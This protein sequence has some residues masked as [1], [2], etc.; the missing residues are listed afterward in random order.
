M[1]DLENRKVADVKAEAAVPALLAP[2]QDEKAP[3]YVQVED[4][5]EADDEEDKH[6]ML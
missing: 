3:L 6:L 5:S 2:A 4:S 1:N